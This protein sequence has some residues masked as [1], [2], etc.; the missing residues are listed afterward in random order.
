MSNFVAAAVP[1]ELR[2]RFPDADW[3]MVKTADGSGRSSLTVQ[4]VIGGVE[5]R[6][7]VDYSYDRFDEDEL[8]D[9]LAQQLAA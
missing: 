4:A 6:A 1:R 2:A 7:S 5:R 8:I 9:S 3:L